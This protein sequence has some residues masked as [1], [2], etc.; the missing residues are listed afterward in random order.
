MLLSRLQRDSG[1]WYG[2]GAALDPVFDGALHL[3]QPALNATVL[4]YRRG[5]EITIQQGIVFVW[6]ECHLHSI[7]NRVRGANEP[8]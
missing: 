8:V 1:T 2:S 7:V 4:K 6:H 5:L 3:N